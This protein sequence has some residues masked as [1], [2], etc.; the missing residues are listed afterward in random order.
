V[1]ATNK[2]QPLSQRRSQTRD[3]IV[4]AATS[5]VALRGFDAATVDEI[6]QESGFSI[7]ALYSN[8]KGKDALF[9]AVFDGHLEWFEKT[10]G[11]A[12]EVT[13]PAGAITDWFSSLTK[14]KDQFLIFTEFW[15]YAV[16]SPKLRREFARRMGQMRT[17]I[18][19]VLAAR[20]EQSGQPSP[21]P[22]DTMALLF[23]A[24]MRGLMLEKLAD[25]KSVPDEEIGRLLAAAIP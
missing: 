3:R 20:A 8:F 2:K 14:S 4:Q 10:F 16:R 22:P 7:G 12:S 1:A 9:L 13:D 24:L 21:L 25:P 17:M 19:S 5:V 18:S 11:E 15:S 23:L 6:A